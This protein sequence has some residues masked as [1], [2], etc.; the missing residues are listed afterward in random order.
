[1]APQKR[2]ARSDSSDHTPNSVVAVPLRPLTPREKEVLRLIAA[3]KRNKEI[4]DLLGCSPRTAHKHTENI[5]EKLCVQTRTAACAWWHETQRS[6]A[7]LF[8]SK[9]E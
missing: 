6:L 2:H 4:A 5:F 3:G 8:V 7:G 9:T 1:M